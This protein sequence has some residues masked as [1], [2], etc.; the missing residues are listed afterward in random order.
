M[1]SPTPINAKELETNSS[2]P[3]PPPPSITTNN[4]MYVQAEPW[5]FREVVQKLTG[6][7]EDSPHKLP[8]SGPPRSGRAP[9]PPPPASL[10]ERQKLQERRRAPA[11][12]EIK[13]GPSS[14][15]YS[16]PYHHLWSGKAEAAGFSS[17]VSTADPFFFNISSP[18]P[19]TPSPSSLKEEGGREERA[20][21]DNGFY[22]YPSPRSGGEPPKLLPLFPLHSPRGSSPP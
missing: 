1:A 12:L 8:V 17:P 22:L 3:P 15:R 10:L 18:S 16:R 6:V 20:I 5:A 2:P 19:T 21:A 11:K 7:P 14:V 13:L 4:T 9:P